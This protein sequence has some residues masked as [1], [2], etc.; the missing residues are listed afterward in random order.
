MW[1]GLSL[2]NKVLLIFG[3][4][5]VLIVLAALSVPWV[6]MNALVD[7]G[8][9]ELS[10]QLVD[11]WERLD[12]V[13]GPVQTQPEYGS[14]IEHAGIRATRLTVPQA[15]GEARSNKFVARALARFQDDPDRAEVQDASWTGVQREYRYARALRSERTKELTGIVVLQRRPFKAAQLLVINTAY[16]LG[17]GVVVLG[18]AIL[19]FYYLTH[20]IILNPVR[21]LKIT[22]ERIREGDLAVRSE[23]SLCKSIH[24]SARR[25]IPP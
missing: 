24:P 21:T 25:V 9:L 18:L 13:P 15:E 22:A 19:A 3:A 6:R 11:A 4:A 7:E 2:A 12:L 17:A 16:L 10:R 1:R 14:T 5:L 23:T 8:Q 20:R